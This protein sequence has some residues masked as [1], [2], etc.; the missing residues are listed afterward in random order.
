M[1]SRLL[2]L[3]SRVAVLV[4]IP[5]TIMVLFASVAVARRVGD[6]NRLH[7]QLSNADAAQELSSMV[8]AVQLEGGR[9]AQWVA[10]PSD[11]TRALLEQA[12][13]VTDAA[14]PDWRHTLN[15]LD[16]E[17]ARYYGAALE[18]LAELPSLRTLADTEPG[19]GRAVT[20]YRTVVE[21]LLAGSDLV[22][23]HIEL[24]GPFAR[25][26]AALDVTGRLGQSLAAE[27]DL[28]VGVIGRGSFVGAEYEEYTAFVAGRD[29]LAAIY[30]Q[31]FDGSPG[32][33]DLDTVMASGLTLTIEDARRAALASVNGSPIAV[34]STAWFD[35]MTDVL[36]EV[37]ALRARLAAGIV[38]DIERQSAAAE[39]SLLLYS[40]V[41]LTA[42]AGYGG[43]WWLMNAWIR[44]PFEAL[45]AEVTETARVRLPA[46]VAAAGNP[47][48]HTRPHD[49]Y[50][51]T[52][53]GGQELV[54]LAEAFNEAQE[55]VVALAA[56][57]AL[58][59]RN[60]GD[61][62][63]NL[64]RRNQ[65]LVTRQLA[66]IDRLERRE[67]DPEILEN[68]FRLDHLATRMRRN[69]ESLLVLAGTE[70]PRTWS[71]PVSVGDAV[72]AAVA[73][74]E[75]YERVEIR[76]MPAAKL[77]GS[78]TSNVSH[79]L[80]ELIENGLSFSPPESSVV[81]HGQ[82][83]DDGYIV[84]IVD[85]GIGIDSAELAH[86]NERLANSGLAELA[87]SRYLGLFVVSRLASR[88]GIKVELAANV[89][90][91]TRATVTLPSGLLVAEP[92]G[93]GAISSNGLSAFAHHPA[94]PERPEPPGPLP[95]GSVWNSP[96][97]SDGP[98]APPPVSP[99]PVVWTEPDPAP[100]LG[101]LGAAAT[102]DTAADTAAHG[103]IEPLVVAPA[104]EAAT[105]AEVAT[106]AVS[107]QGD[108]P[109]AAR[110]PATEVLASGLRRRAPRPG[111]QEG[112]HRLVAVPEPDDT[113]PPRRSAA[114]VRR[115][116]TMFQAA[117]HR[118]LQHSASTPPAEGEEER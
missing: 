24:D 70:T 16:A 76:A 36:G 38:A 89:D 12:R 47:E 88:Y 56:E 114:E 94:A 53:S 60:V 13:A 61:I 11:A 35:D 78:M 52:S 104:T 105:A 30:R 40:G 5:L 93:P 34:D 74:V 10:E 86:L 21:A 100:S 9:T 3:R 111:G 66:F 2:S 45:I 51:I 77:R 116:L 33:Q 82:V 110:P 73:E 8:A 43:A 106:E 49:L 37:E 28:L 98:A 85:R 57:Q 55:H 84:T 91:G 83:H 59:R 29:V 90:G 68:L 46:A 48:P 92:H 113:E 17:N 79:L 64:G 69:A 75:Q 26:A 65:K 62:F 25:G 7:A 108:G 42:I 96:A 54:D 80:A 117:Q 4:A 23:K 22:V 107:S 72:R 97:P 101:R 44:R 31:T 50:R 95:D 112:A 99:E 103:R 20:R 63:A 71:A 81:V 6:V 27:R 87:P 115:L 41:A 18:R 102:S 58:V 19:T 15:R 39:S 32:E 14:L 109:P 1:A 118:A 67:Q